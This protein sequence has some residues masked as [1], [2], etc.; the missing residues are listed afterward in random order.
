MLRISI[1]SYF[2]L[3]IQNISAQDS[4][5][6]VA[7]ESFQFHSIG[8]LSKDSLVIVTC[9]DYVYFPFGKIDKSSEL[10][11]SVLKNFNVFSH[12]EKQDNG[13]FLFHSMTHKSS[14][15]LL[16]FDD[17]PEASIHS[18]ILKGEILDNSVSFVNSIK[19]GMDS[20]SFFSEFFDRYPNEW[21][22]CKTI[23]FEACVDD[24]KHIYS[25]TNAILFTLNSKRILPGNYK[26]ML[27]PNQSLKRTL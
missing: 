25:F 8:K 11:S 4:L 21:K 18:Y 19:I 6:L 17:D 13:E 9:A 5:V 26:S 3:L 16:W 14:H 23:I 1:L 7:K 2:I 12:L 10:I 20:Q 24:I 27:L 22:K 15:L